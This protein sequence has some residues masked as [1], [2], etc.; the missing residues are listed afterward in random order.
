MCIAAPCGVVR[1]NLT[2]PLRQ[3]QGGATI[4]GNARG[5]YE[6]LGAVLAG[7][8]ELLDPLPEL[9][10]PLLELAL[11]A[12]PLALEPPPDFASA[13]ES[14]REKPLP[15]KVTPTALKSL[16]SRPEQD[17]HSVRESSVNAWT[18]SKALPHSVQR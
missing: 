10:D 15:L 1:S 3:R 5:R 13:R 16:R 18:M 14:V 12:A 11:D 4:R 7:A 2:A 8:A 9:L 6:P 17:G